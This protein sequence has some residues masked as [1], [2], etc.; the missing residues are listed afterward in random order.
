M[1]YAT[2]TLLS[3]RLCNFFRRCYSWWDIET[4]S[5]DLTERGRRI[6]LSSGRFAQ[7]S[8]RGTEFT[9]ERTA[10]VSERPAAAREFSNDCLIFS[11]PKPE[12]RAAAIASL[13][14]AVQ[15]RDAFEHFLCKAPRGRGLD[16]GEHDLNFRSQESPG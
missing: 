6:T 9:F 5:A 3:N 15:K 7:K 1:R 2:L 12:Q 4:S 16:E 10:A 13:I 11:V 8:N 14:A